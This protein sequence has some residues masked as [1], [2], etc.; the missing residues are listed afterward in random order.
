[1]PPTPAWYLAQP[2]PRN[3]ALY[4]A[5]R[6]GRYTLSEVAAAVGLSVSR[7]NRIVVAVKR[8]T[9]TSRTARN[10]MPPG[11]RT[12]QTDGEQVTLAR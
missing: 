9:A 7:V 6:H 12:R 11:P 10:G 8:R 2:D 3:E 4:R 1:M 5:R